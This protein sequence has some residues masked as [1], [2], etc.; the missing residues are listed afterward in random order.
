MT[1]VWFDYTE[2]PPKSPLET[3]GHGLPMVENH[4]PPAVLQTKATLETFPPPGLGLSMTSYGME[5]PFGQFGLSIL[6][7]SPAASCPPKDYWLRG[8]WEKQKRL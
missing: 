4:P 6:P 8:E 7:V 2:T 3:W 1:F 5:Y